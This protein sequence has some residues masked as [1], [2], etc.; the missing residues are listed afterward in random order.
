[1]F[2]RADQ[3]STM[4]R[5]FRS[6]RKRGISG[7]LLRSVYNSVD[8]LFDVRHKVDTASLVGWDAMNIDDGQRQHAQRYYPSRVIPL[9]MLFKTWGIGPGRVLVD[10]GCGKGKV[11]L[12]ASEFGFKE[13]RGVE[14]SPLLCGVAQQNC[15]HYKAE[16]KTK[17]DFVIVD[18][19]VLNY[20]IK[21]DEDVFYL[22]NPFD[23]YILAQVLENIASSLQRRNRTIWLIY[24]NPIHRN[25]IEEKLKPSKIVCFTFWDSSFI[26][27]EVEQANGTQMIPPSPLAM[28]RQADT[29]F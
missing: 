3:V 17:T 6:I 18:S 12:V 8:Y 1:M 14:F 25:L 4:H 19:D 28:G 22:F 16:T 10:F 15:A 5:F 24:C 21:E 23:D 20:T 9:R 7:T 2:T 11:L 26:V 27:F 29:L 13:I